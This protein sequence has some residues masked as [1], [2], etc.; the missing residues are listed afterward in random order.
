[1]DKKEIVKNKMDSKLKWE[2]MLARVG[3]LLDTLTD[4]CGYCEI[5]SV[6]DDCCN[7]CPL[8]SEICSPDATDNSL[9]TQ[10][11]QALNKAW[12]LMRKV[13]QAITTDVE[14]TV[15]GASK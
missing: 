1:M 4:T 12:W 11:E 14:L 8:Y 2:Q 5:Y 6:E 9:V 13:K 10:T 3:S 7:D 15:R